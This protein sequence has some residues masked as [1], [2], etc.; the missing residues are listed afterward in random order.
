MYVYTYL[1]TDVHE[2]VMVVRTVCQHLEVKRAEI[3]LFYNISICM[4]IYMLT[5]YTYQIK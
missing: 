5:Q 3:H 1:H 2:T 4:Y